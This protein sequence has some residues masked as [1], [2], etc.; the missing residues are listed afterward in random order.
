MQDGG[1]QIVYMNFIRRSLEAKLIGLSVGHA[2]F[3]A[4]SCEP[5]CEAV[6][7]V[8]ASVSVLGSRRATK[9]TSPNDQRVLEQ[10]SLFQISQ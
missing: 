9:L 4:S 10:P 8:I 3:Y 5:H 7:I 1:M 2:T 6:M